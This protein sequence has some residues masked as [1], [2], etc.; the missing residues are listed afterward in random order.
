LQFEVKV[1]AVRDATPDELDHG[2]VHGEG[3][4]H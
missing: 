2:H 1:L 3:H 4:E